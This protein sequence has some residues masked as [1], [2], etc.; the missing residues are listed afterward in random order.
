MTLRHS[1]SEILSL[2]VESTLREELQGSSSPRSM[3]YTMQARTQ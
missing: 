2:V 1:T 3:L